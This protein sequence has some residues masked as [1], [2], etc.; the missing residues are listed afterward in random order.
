MSGR[1]KPVHL[2]K[3]VGTL[4][5]V[6]TPVKKNH[7]Y[8]FFFSPFLVFFVASDFE[9]MIMSF[10]LTVTQT[11]QRQTWS[12]LVTFLAFI[13]QPVALQTMP[14]CL[15][16]FLNVRFCLQSFPSCKNIADKCNRVNAPEWS[17][18]CVQTKRVIMHAEA[19]A[20]RKCA[21]GLQN[22]AFSR[23]PEY[24][25]PFESG[26]NVRKTFHRRPVSYV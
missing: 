15:D 17:G 9:Y 24:K 12:C 13:D 20:C 6:L 11:A 22:S 8:L 18:C 14:L 1:L 21:A 3:S 23:Y 25:K 16:G 4:T 2:T 26:Q 7:S 5:I 19:F 10:Q